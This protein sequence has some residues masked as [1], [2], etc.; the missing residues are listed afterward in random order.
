M[1]LSDVQAS[2]SVICDDLPVT[3]SVS[4]YQGPVVWSNSQAG[5]TIEVTEAGSYTAMSTS[6]CVRSSEALMI[7]SSET[8]SCSMYVPNVISRSS[9]L[10][11]A[12]LVISTSCAFQSFQL[13]VYDRWGG[14]VY[15][16]RDHTGGWTGRHDVEGY[17][18]GVYV[19]ALR[20]VYDGEQEERHEY[21]S[22]TLLP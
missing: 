8:C 3:L 1:D 18:P 10:D 13:S 16:S 22:V 7:T 20:Y 15:T 2:S 5:N 9:Q 6:S 11:N 19:V 21:Y 12:R 4:N 14:E 17:S